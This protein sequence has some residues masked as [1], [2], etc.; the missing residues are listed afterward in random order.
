MLML[1]SF[2]A[3]IKQQNLLQKNDRVLVAV[4]GGVDLVVLCELLHWAGFEIGIAHCNFGLREDPVRTA[5]RLLL[6]N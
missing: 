4:S 3:F 1:D 2:L 5:T 6:Y